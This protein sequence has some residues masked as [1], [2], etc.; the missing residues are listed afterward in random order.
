M[1]MLV[2]SKRDKNY[3]IVYNFNFLSH[4]LYVAELLL[5]S[6]QWLNM[7][8]NSLPFIEPGDS[9][10]NT[11]SPYPEMYEHNPLS[12]FKIIFFVL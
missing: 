1:F 7:S 8:R 10:E 6:W 2:K 3:F 5:R 9:Q 12:L 11:S 4:Y